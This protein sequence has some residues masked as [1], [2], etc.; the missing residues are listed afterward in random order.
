MQDESNESLENCRN[1]VNKLG[2]SDG[3]PRIVELCAK[4]EV[5]EL[6]LSRKYKGN[7][8]SVKVTSGRKVSEIIS[9]G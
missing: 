2:N 3:D 6:L 1:L 5:D 8:V 4:L 7:D 9:I